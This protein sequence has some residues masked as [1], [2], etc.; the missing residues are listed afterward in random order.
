MGK[1]SSQHKSYYLLFR[2]KN[3]RLDLLQLPDNEL[4]LCEPKGGKYTTQKTFCQHNNYYLLFHQL[5]FRLDF[6]L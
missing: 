1:V 4:F 6:L 3:F 5:F 2:E